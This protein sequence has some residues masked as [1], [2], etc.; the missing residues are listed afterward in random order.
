[1]KVN[2]IE[3]YIW[4]K[5]LISHDLLKILLATWSFLLYPFCT[6]KQCFKK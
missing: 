3:L 5:Y 6:S 2:S 1:M 4:L